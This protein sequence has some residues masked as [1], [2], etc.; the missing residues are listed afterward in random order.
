MKSFLTL[1][2]KTTSP[3]KA[4]SK[5]ED[6]WEEYHANYLSSKDIEDQQEDMDEKPLHQEE[7]LFE[8]TKT[9]QYVPNRKQIK[10]QSAKVVEELSKKE[11]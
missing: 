9:T 8:D 4:E 10:L 5:L 6:L 2:G 1:T 3:P 7:E 11:D